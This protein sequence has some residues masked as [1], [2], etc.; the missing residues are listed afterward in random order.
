MRRGVPQAT[1]GDLRSLSEAA[2]DCRA[3]TDPAARLDAN[4]RFHR[5]LHALA[6]SRQLS[7][8]IDLLWDSTDA[9]R[10]LYYALPGEA[11]EADRAHA[12]I[13]AAVADGDAERA[14]QLEDAHRDR[15]LARLR[16]AL[17]QAA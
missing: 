12:E 5:R 11:A 1:A 15:A 14:V 17:G 6:G 9:Y 7:R 13:L 10:A 8:V 4:R 16:E 2:E 3:A